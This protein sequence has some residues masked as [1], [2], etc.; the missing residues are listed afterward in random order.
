MSSATDPLV[1]SGPTGDTAARAG[2]DEVVRITSLSFAWPGDRAPVLSIDALSIA[3]GERVLLRG[4]SGSGKSTL[5]SAI[6]GVVDIPAGTVTLAGT[7]IGGLRSS[8]R[9]RFRVDHT[10]MIFQLFNLIPWLSALDN[11]LLPCRF[12]ARRARRAGENPPATAARLLGEL[13]L[14]ELELQRAPAQSLSVGQQQRVAAARALIGGPDL[15]LA[16]EPTSALDEAAKAVFVDLLLRECA[17]VGASLLFVSH[18]PDL[19]R[20]FDRVIDMT[21]L[22]GGWRPC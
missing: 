16:D 10:G 19:E 9:D 18:D 5:L 20:H 22:N 1:D 12:S 11:V 15:I 3:R 8:A 14:G 7:D 6:A 4:P 13:G 21:E 17:Q 2:V